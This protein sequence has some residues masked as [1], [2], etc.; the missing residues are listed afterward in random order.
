MMKL[1]LLVLLGSSSPALDTAAPLPLHLPP[2]VGPATRPLGFQY[3]GFDR[4]PAFYFG[5]RP[6]GLQT[7]PQLAA[8]ARFSLVGWGWEQGLGPRCVGCNSWHPFVNFSS[9]LAGLHFC[10]SEQRLSESATRFRATPDVGPTLAQH[11][12]GDDAT[13]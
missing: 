2:L 4:F 5:S 12:P 3:T 7:E 1:M 11:Q 13:H 10:S 6:E 8:M 9:S